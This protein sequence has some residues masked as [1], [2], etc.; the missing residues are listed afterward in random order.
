MRAACAVDDEERQHLVERVGQFGVEAAGIDGID[1]EAPAGA[2]ER[3]G[4]VAEAVMA[5]VF[6]PLHRV[7]Q[8]W[9]LRDIK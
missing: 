1:R 9:V 5:L 6:V 3:A 2:I 4:L 8:R 7:Q